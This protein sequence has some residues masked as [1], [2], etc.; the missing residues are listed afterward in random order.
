MN[1]TPISR[2]SLAPPPGRLEARSRSMRGDG[3]ARILAGARQRRLE[4]Q[5]WRQASDQGVDVATIEAE[6]A[7][8]ELGLDL[9][10]PL[11]GRTGIAADI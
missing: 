1:S 5:E 9:V 6:E 10:S 2:S 7:T 8:H 3:G 11:N 4:V